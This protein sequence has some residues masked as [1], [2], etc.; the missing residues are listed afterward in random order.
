MG[1]QRHRVACCLLPA[2][3]EEC[4]L[5]TGGGALQGDPYAVAS[6]VR[7][8]RPVIDECVDACVER[9]PLERL[10]YV[11]RVPASARN[12]VRSS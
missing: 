6:F 9:D 3:D 4:L 2:S 12:R 11:C 1:M 5:Q 7:V 10:L 8:F